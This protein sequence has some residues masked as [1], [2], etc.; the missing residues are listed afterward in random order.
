M[1]AATDPR[2]AVPVKPQRPGP[3]DWPAQPGAA[4][5]CLW[6]GDKVCAYSLTIDDN[7]APN[8]P[9]WIEQGERFGFRFTWF[10]ITGR[11]ADEEGKGDFG[12]DWP[13]FNRLHALGH[14]IQSHTVTHLHGD[15]PIAEE[16]AQS[17]AMI[18]TR[19]PGHRCRTLAYP[20]GGRSR[21]AK[22]IPVVENDPAVASMHYVGARG[23]AG[24][25]TPAI[26]MPYL[27]T[28]KNN[29]FFEGDRFALETFLDPM[30]SNYRGWHINTCHLIKDDRKQSIIEGLQRI[31][32]HEADIWMGTFTAVLLYARQRDAASLTS[33][34]TD[35]QA[36]AFTLGDSLD[37]D[38]FDQPLTVKVRLFPEWQGC[39]AE[40]GGSPLPCR[41][42]THE[43]GNFALVDAVPDRGQ[44][45][46]LP[47]TDLGH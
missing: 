28:G 43:G 35:T 22:G 8:I 4:S 27:R 41:I 5:I 1:D 45:L 12:G 39:R 20:G 10:V 37:D 6:Q 26:G 33:D 21:A 3:R 15:L 29:G 30:N 25:V 17:K 40:Q 36:L 2:W 11:I 19:I 14:D 31:K 7:C 38:T 24:F 16:Y 34:R 18:E 42:V 44:V 32:Q 9:F 13:T 47:A 23:A 46:V